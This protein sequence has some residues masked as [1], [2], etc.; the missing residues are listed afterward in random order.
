MGK[1]EGRAILNHFS[2]DYIAKE[3]KTWEP[4]EF[5]SIT[6][7]KGRTGILDSFTSF[8]YITLVFRNFRKDELTRIRVI[9]K[10]FLVPPASH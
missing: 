5:L 8:H 3:S 6:V 4:S 7:L 9:Y 1:K 10:A 2:W